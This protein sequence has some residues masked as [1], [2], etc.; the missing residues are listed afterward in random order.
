LL[1]AA[2]GAVYADEKFIHT[3]MEFFFHKVMY[4]GY[5]VSWFVDLMDLKN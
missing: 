5:D 1:D 3:Y 4:A 2:V